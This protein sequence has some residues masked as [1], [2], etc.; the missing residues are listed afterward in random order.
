MQTRRTLLHLVAGAATLPIAPSVARA[1]TYPARS[2]RIIVDFPP[3]GGTD[4]AARLLTQWLSMRLGQPFV[5]E[6][7]PGAATNIATEA[8]AKAAADGYT[9]AMVGTSAAIN[10]ALYHKPNFN[11]KI[12]IAPVASIYRIP[13]VMEVNPSVP[14]TTVPEFIAYAKANPGKINMASAGNGSVQHVSGELFKIMAGV[15]MVH[16]PYRGAAPAVIDLI[17]G[18]VQI[19]FDSTGSSIEHIKAG[20]LR[21]LAVTT[22][23][24]WEGLPD[25]PIVGEFLPGYDTSAVQGIGAPRN[26][27]AEIVHKLN[28]EINGA[29]A[30]PKFKARLAELG[31]TVFGG[32][33]ADFGRLIGE[34]VEKWGKVIR[35]AGIKAD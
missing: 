5:I 8:V 6:N 34:E 19:M 1:Q 13:Y 23:T 20:K 7:R 11:L 18:Q 10:A 26:T 32:T 4:L 21:A 3:G 33:P 35:E 31:S 28:N 14:A 12:D 15:N 22:T 29:L 30:D 9:L 24:R 27:P 16:V 2:V 17:A 25:I